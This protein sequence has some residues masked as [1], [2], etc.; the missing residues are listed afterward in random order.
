MVQIL[1]V[2]FHFSAFTNAFQ[3]T[4]SSF[5]KT[6]LDQE[7]D[8]PLLKPDTWYAQSHMTVLYV[9]YTCHDIFIGL[10]N[11]VMALT[12]SVYSSYQV[13]GLSFGLYY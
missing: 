6:P 3:L 10:A 7:P 12:Q 11:R 13:R 2:Y 5:S 9:S 1:S 4:L 8:V